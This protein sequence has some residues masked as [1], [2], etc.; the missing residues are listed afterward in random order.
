MARVTGPLFSM[1]ASGTVGKTI[2]FA[3]WKGRAYVRERVI[4]ANPKSAKQTGIRAMMSFLSQAWTSISALSKA[5][6][7]ELAAQKSISTFNAFGSETLSRWQNVSTPTQTYPAAEASTPL[8][9]TTQ[10]LT[11]GE[12]CVTVAIT[13]SGD[14]NIWGLLVFRD[15]AEIT[16]PSWANCVAVLMANGANAVTWVDSP[17]DAGTYHYRTA[18]FNTDGILGTVKADDT[19]VAT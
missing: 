14:T 4:P 1:S 18:V 6:W 16:A 7:E 17:L 10:T 11:G 5:T 12:G 2:T 19:A 9:V 15:T 13:P 3:S 8:T